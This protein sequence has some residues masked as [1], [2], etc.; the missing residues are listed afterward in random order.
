MSE[1]DDLHKSHGPMEKIMHKLESLEAAQSEQH[2]NQQAEMKR[3]ST[4]LLGDPEMHVDGLIQRHTQL[5]KDIDNNKE[6]INRHGLWMT[7]HDK[8]QARQQGI[9][10]GLMTAWGLVIK[11]WSNLFGT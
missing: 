3:I 11:F 2:R 6:L 1:I 7:K 9:V 5:Q 10:Y 4:A 8:Q